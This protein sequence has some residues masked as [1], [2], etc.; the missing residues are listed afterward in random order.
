MNK[1]LCFI[2]SRI[3]NLYELEMNTFSN[4]IRCGAINRL[5]NFDLST[6]FR[7]PVPEK[8]S[9][10]IT[11]SVSRFHLEKGIILKMKLVLLF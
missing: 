6:P 9:A 2:L 3:V 11:S 10:N 7:I 5:K 4:C 1:L 8:K